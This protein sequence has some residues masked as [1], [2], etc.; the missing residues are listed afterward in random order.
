MLCFAFNSIENR[1]ICEISV[2]AIMFSKCCLTSLVTRSDGETGGARMETTERALKGPHDT[3]S[4]PVVKITQFGNKSLLN[5]RCN[6]DEQSMR[7]PT[8][9]VTMISWTTFSVG[10]NFALVAVMLSQPSPALNWF[11]K[12]IHVLPQSEH[13]TKSMNGSSDACHNSQKTDKLLCIP[14]PASPRLSS[15][16]S[17]HVRFCSGNGHYV[18]TNEDHQSAEAPG[19]CHCHGCFSGVHCGELDPECLLNLF[20]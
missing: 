19:A 15:S 11:S 16:A 8:R 5:G 13:L 20:Q 3:S 9:R 17:D 12:A 18:V 1:K 7:P 10:V 2:P 4:S 6:D 14:R